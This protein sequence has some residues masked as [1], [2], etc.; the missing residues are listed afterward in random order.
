MRP[1]LILAHGTRT[2]KVEWEGYDEYVTSADVL[3]IDLP[4]HG[5]LEGTRC[6]FDDVVRVFDEA[7]ECAEPGRAV[8]VGGH[9]LGGYL[10][11]MYAAHRARTGRPGPDG[12]VLIGTSADPGSSL[13]FVYKG[14][15]KVLPVVGFERMTRVANVFYRL[16]GYDGPMPGPESY[17]ALAD[18]WDLVFERCGPDNLRGLGCD[19]DI[20]NGQYDQMRI[21]ARR[22]A[23]AAGGARTHVV[24][25]G[26]HLM[27]TTHPVELAAILDSIARRHSV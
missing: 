2:S 26:S 15:A 11:A 25:G 17:A 10:A 23:E 21:H 18:A 5:E 22:F 4:G 14:F 27:P 24:R 1:L 6:L 12:L 13:A 9:S 7:V 8:I 3:P 19:V 16:L 20:V